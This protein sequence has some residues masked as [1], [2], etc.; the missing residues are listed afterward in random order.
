MKHILFFIT[1]FVGGGA[2]KALI[3]LLKVFDYSRFR[4]T[5]CLLYY[6]GEYLDSIPKE[7]NV[8]VLYPR[9]NSFYRKSFRYYRKYQNTLLFKFRLWQKLG[10]SYDVIISF[11]EGYPLVFHSLVADRALKN[12]TWVHCDLLNFHY[13]VPDAFK[14][15]EAERE[16][17][18]KMDDIV[19][20]SKNIMSN[21]EK[22]YQLG[23]NHFCLYNL[24]DVNAIRMAGGKKDDLLRTGTVITAIGRLAPV[25]GYDRLLRLAKRLKDEGYAFSVQI[26]GQGEELD[27]LIDLSKR[28]NVQA[29]VV[30]MGFKSNPYPYLSNSDIYISTSLSEGLSLVICEALVLGLPVIAT[31]TAGAL[32]LLDNGEYGVLTEHTDESIYEGITALLNNEDLR[33]EFSKKSLERAEM[34]N[35]A[36]TMDTIYQL[37]L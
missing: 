8:I 31:K 32:E 9:R 16:A 3:E 29:E 12:I 7:V 28:L 30:F 6:E 21:F 20:V 37:V 34:F 10:K 11:L 26:I 2:E 25:K 13:T 14:Y 35:M 19:F 23:N 27:N 33:R 1:S 22:M 15:E 5:V 17:Y 24:I 18:A 4:V 36:Q